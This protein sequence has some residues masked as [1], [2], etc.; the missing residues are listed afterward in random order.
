MHRNLEFK[1]NPSYLLHFRKMS[2]KSKPKIKYCNKVVPCAKQQIITD[3]SDDITSGCLLGRVWGGL[4][5]PPAVIN[6]YSQ[7]TRCSLYPSWKHER[8]SQ[9]WEP[10]IRQD[11]TQFMGRAF[12][13]SSAYHSA[14][15]ETQK[16]V[17]KNR[18][19]PCTVLPHNFWP[20]LSI[21]TP[22]CHTFVCSPWGSDQVFA[23][24]L[25]R[26]VEPR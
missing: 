2:R 15:H 9:P 10:D 12:D 16:L 3:P 21:E 20:R 4:P 18:Q 24:I 7:E 25:E 6:F 19:L 14:P 5:L 17:R 23:G 11:Q 13:C 1:K 22:P 8:L 26:L